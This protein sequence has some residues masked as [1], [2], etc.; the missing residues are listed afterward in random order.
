MKTARKRSRPTHIFRERR[1]QIWDNPAIQ[2][3]VAD[4][5]HRSVCQYTD[6]DGYLQCEYYA[7]AGQGLLQRE[8]GLEMMLQAGEM[9]LTVNQELSVGT[10]FDGKEYGSWHV[11]LG[12][13]LGFIIDFA[14]RHYRNYHERSKTAKLAEWSEAEPPKYIWTTTMK[15]PKGLWLNA[16]QEATDQVYEMQEISP[17]YRLI[18][19]AVKEYQGGDL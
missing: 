5:V 17:C 1:R 15:L 7:L 11:W 3:R 8:F 9:Q 13:Q 6:T 19:L 4:A 2:E 12:S 10:H 16:L 14:A 18:N